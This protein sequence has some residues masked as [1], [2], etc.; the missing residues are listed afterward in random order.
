MVNRLI[1][2]TAK[3]AE[4]IGV[5]IT[6]VIFAVMLAQ[7]F[8]RYVLNSSLLWSEDV[9]LWGLAWLVFVAAGPVMRTWSHVHVPLFVRAFPLPVRARLIV[10]SKLLTAAFLLFLVW[11]GTVSVFAGYHRVAEMLGLSTRWVKLAIPVGSALM[12]AFLLAG[13]ARDMRALARRD[14]DHFADYGRPD[15]G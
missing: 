6:I 8:F 9:A 13:I 4:A 10:L 12:L 14:A 7:I 1:D 15:A 5:A 11:Q 3:A 2:R